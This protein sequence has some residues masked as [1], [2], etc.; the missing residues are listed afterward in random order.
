M[1]DIATMTDIT[2]ATGTD[3][4]EILTEINSNVELL[5]LAF[6]MFECIKMAR[7]G[8]NRLYRGKGV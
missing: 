7:Y 3:C 6:V 8:L 2:K 1:V 4:V 5:L